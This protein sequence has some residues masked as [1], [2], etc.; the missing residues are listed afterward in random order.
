MGAGDDF[1]AVGPALLQADGSERDE[2]I[3]P[4]VGAMIEG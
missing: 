1:R 4:S 2:L 3:E